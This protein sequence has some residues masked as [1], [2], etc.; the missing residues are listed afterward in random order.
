MKL[1]TAKKIIRKVNGI[2]Y[3]DTKGYLFKT[4]IQALK[5]LEKHKIKP[6]EIL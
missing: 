3:K 2:K 1:R 4:A 5:V 6:S